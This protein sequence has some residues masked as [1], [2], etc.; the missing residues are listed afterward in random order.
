MAVGQPTLKTLTTH[1][2]SQS[3]NRYTAYACL[4]VIL[5]PLVTSSVPD[6]Q[7]LLK[8][9]G[10]ALNACYHGRAGRRITRDQRT[11]WPLACWPGVG[12]PAYADLHPRSVQHCCHTPLRAVHL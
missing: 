3:A 6:I 9:M 1:S 7:G 5:A 2:S 11:S 8:A 10:H 4:T 12:G